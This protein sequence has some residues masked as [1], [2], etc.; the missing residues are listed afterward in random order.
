[1]TQ[2]TSKKLQLFVLPYALIAAFVRVS[3]DYFTKMGI[4]SPLI[5]RFSFLF[6]FVLEVVLII[7][8][9][10]KFKAINSDIL[11]LKEGLKVGIIVMLIIGLFFSVGSYIHDTYINP[12]FQKNIFIASQQGSEQTTEY[13]QN[14][15]PIGIF[16]ST[17]RFILLGFVISLVTSSFFKSKDQ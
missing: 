16:L 13:T 7:F 11:T 12:E 5:Y 17:I 8:L 1:M 15:N 4:D 10:K 14:N 3:I 6:C 9:T 2:A